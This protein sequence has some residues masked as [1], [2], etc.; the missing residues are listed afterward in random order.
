[1]PALPLAGAVC[2]SATRAAHALMKQGAIWWGLASLFAWGEKDSGGHALRETTS[3]GLC[4][5]VCP[6]RTSERGKGRLC[7]RRRGRG[8]EARDIHTPDTLG[9]GKCTISRKKHHLAEIYYIC[10]GLSERPL[11]HFHQTKWPVRRELNWRQ[12]TAPLWP[13][14]SRSSSHCR[15]CS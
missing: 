4:G 9:V 1:V 13:S 11:K 12:K 6:S 14:S 10:A 7:E 3:R 15:C 8:R 5:L 2:A